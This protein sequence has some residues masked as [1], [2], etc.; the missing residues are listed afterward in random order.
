MANS[1]GTSSSTLG[2][3]NR[4]A[5]LMSGLDT[6]ALVKASTS[7]TKISINKKKQKLQTLE[8]KQTQ[9]RD[10]I[11]SLSSFQSKYLDILSP[12]SIRANSIMKKFK[13]VSS[14][15]DLN[16]SAASGSTPTSYSISSSKK[17]AA[18]VLQGKAAS[19]GSIDLDFSKANEGSNTV[20]ITLDGTT[21]SVTFEG[22]ADVKDNFLNALNDAF[23]GIT[24]AEFAFK[25][26]EGSTDLK[27]K[28]ILNTVPG[29]KVSHSFSANYNSAIGLANDASSK[30]SKS[31]KLGDIDFLTELQGSKFEFSINGKNFSF[32]KDNT[33]NDVLEAVNNSKAGVTMSFNSLSQSFKL[34]TSK[35]GA[36]EEIE[37]SQTRGNLLNSMMGIEEGTGA[38][39]LAAGGSV[40]N[41][42][43]QK[44]LNGNELSTTQLT[45]NGYKKGVY[46]D[47]T[48]GDDSLRLDLSAL[49]ARLETSGDKFTAA[50]GKEY[51]L[52]ILNDKD[53]NLAFYS[54][55]DDKGTTHYLD[56]NKDQICATNA[57]TGKNYDA[58][59]NVISASKCND[60]IKNSGLNKAEIQ[61]H[62]FTAAEYAEEYNNALVNA[63]AKT[64]EIQANALQSAAQ[65]LGY[66]A[67]DEDFT[68]DALD[69]LSAEQQEELYAKMNEK[70]E[71]LAKNKISTLGIEFKT[72]TDADGKDKMYLDAGTHAVSLTQGK[73]FGFENSSN[74][75]VS[76]IDPDKAITDKTSLTFTYTDENGNSAEKTVTNA[77][78]ITV[79]DLLDMGIFDYDSS[80]GV[81]TMTGGGSLTGA[82]S[83][84]REFLKDA[85]DSTSISGADRTNTLSA[86]G[87]NAQI[88]I[89]GVTIESATNS[90]TV[91]GTTFD[92]SGLDDFDA[93]VDPDKEINVTTSRDTSS[94][95]EVIT[96]FVNDYNTLI[97][98][99]YDKINE[100]RPKSNGSYYD[101]LT[102][103]QEEEMSEDEIEKW[104]EQAQ[105]GLL[106]NDPTL[107]KFISQMRMAM[108]S[109]SNG[110]TLAAMGITL[111]SGSINGELSIDEDKLDSAI[112]KYGD[113]IA[114]FFT[115]MED[116]FAKNLNDTFDRAISTK[117]KK[118]GYFTNLVGVENTMSAKNNQYY[119]QMNSIQEMIDRLN[120]KYEK[121]QERYWAKF[122]SLETYLN[123]MNM[124]SSMFATTA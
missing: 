96:N 108:S 27:D 50:D 46:L 97:K 74:F 23:D 111:D 7:N 41:A 91:D 31:S 115:D 102:E 72:T 76:G 105:K 1:S 68:A 51:D 101:P 123:K 59:G 35:T 114:K 82:D 26:G 22:G 39:Q 30:I 55:K 36:G 57:S 62:K 61:Y 18:A 10:I 53:G 52:N 6:E 73:N 94:I 99:L 67:I 89:D 78:G 107:N 84:T 44:N 93:A 38:G 16:V 66:V 88:T 34:Q 70:A 103:E 58:D 124:Q 9:Y 28:L 8:W 100:T 29:D 112:S 98:S 20:K 11:S 49:E 109:A 33:V 64:D 75:D 47:M 118:Y 81:L 17:A 4:M 90:F 24:S 60:L 92:V 87:T 110:M 106:L 25:G 69:G 48:I 117:S 19:A 15:S 56:L 3:T 122:S 32:T 21:K 85:F 63:Y 40:S 116:G 120:D 86:Y 42:Y 65:D 14:N 77:G 71:E 95:K 80:T 119:S 104:N 12:T 113:E 45:E 121:Q 37:I 83:S 79:N 5:G 54:Y 2:D 43:T 13:A